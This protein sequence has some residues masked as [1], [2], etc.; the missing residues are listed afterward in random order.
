MV[1]AQIPVC[2]PPQAVPVT[3]LSVLLI[4]GTPPEGS[5]RGHAGGSPEEMAFCTGEQPVGLGLPGSPARLEQAGQ[6]PPWG[7]PFLGGQGVLQS[8]THA[9]IP[10]PN[11]G[12]GL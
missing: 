11:P 5:S 4:L 10:S 6:G 7:L 2:P 8:G 3:G 9:Q 12:S 1:L